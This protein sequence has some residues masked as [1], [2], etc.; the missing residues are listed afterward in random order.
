VIVALGRDTTEAPYERRVRNW[1]GEP[2]MD[3]DVILGVE[4][5]LSIEEVVGSIRRLHLNEGQEQADRLNAHLHALGTDK[6]VYGALFVRRTGEP[7]TEPPLRLRMTSRATA[8]DFDRLFA[9]RKHRRCAGFGDWLKAAKP[10]L[11]PHLEVKDRRLVKNGA[12]VAGETLLWVEQAFSAALQVDPWV[13][14]IIASF[15]DGHTIEQVFSAA[16]RADQ[17]PSDFTL[18]TLIDLV[19][20][21]IEYGFLEVDFP[22]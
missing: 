1:L 8:A 6:F 9:W 2:G 17:L 21:L 14:P 15:T 3:C 22:C 19:T 11:S 13:M 12:L 7:V 20:M 16:E 10:R 18:P 5:L 4:K